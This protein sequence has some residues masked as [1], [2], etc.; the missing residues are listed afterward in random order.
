[1]KSTKK[2][3]KDKIK[4]VPRKVA[5]NTVL[6]SGLKVT[7]SFVSFI[8]LSFITRL[9]GPEGFGAYSTIMA[10]FSM[11]S[12][13][14]DLGINQTVLRE[15]AKTE[16]KKQ[17]ARLIST[18][19]SIKLAFTCFLF[20]ASFVFV[21]FLNYSQDI[22]NGIVIVLIGLIFASLYQSLT[23]VFQKRLL[24]YYVSM[25]ELAGRIANLIWVLVC[26]KLDLG[27]AWVVIGLILSWAT[28][29][30]IV[31]TLTKK[32]L[33]IGLDFNLKRIKKLLKE[34]LPLGISAIVTFI[35]LRFDTIILSSIKGM[36]DVGIYNLAYKVFE[37]LAYFPAMFMGLILPLFSK[38]I[39]YNKNKFKNIANKTFDAISLI[40][41]GVSMGIFSL[42]PK[43][44]SI[45]GGDG[46]EE[47]V[48]V[49][50]IITLAIFGI[51]MGQFFNSI[52]ISAKKQKNLLVIFV[53]AAILNVVLNLIFIPK[54]SFYASA[55]ISVITELL[56]PLLSFLVVWKSIQY[57]PNIKSLIKIIIAGIVMSL[58]IIFTNKISFGAENTFIKIGVLV[59]QVLIGGGLYLLTA[60]LLK[61]FSKKDFES[62][63]TKNR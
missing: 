10:F 63:I 26:Y 37:N 27:L 22:K 17:E 55:A 49:L 6:S 1:M 7:W 21:K 3:G 32:R 18:A 25:A 60:Y 9:L 28:T 40:A 50:K 33:D 41:V 13:V 44:V 19:I 4:S 42:A 15:I 31:I 61:A 36:E 24:A 8:A 2:A 54:Y 29:F 58:F 11:F 38:N 45:I 51:F 34:A 35:Y 48:I 57:L 62:L 53:T 46:F 30:S 39:F 43:V 59:F 47:S 5:L 23:G 52:L 56:V 20:L 12:A 16:N 14:S